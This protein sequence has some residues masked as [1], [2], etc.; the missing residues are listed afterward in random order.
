MCVEERECVSMYVCVRVCL[1]E[2]DKNVCIRGKSVCVST[3][4]HESER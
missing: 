2:W 4:G 3:F 1:Y